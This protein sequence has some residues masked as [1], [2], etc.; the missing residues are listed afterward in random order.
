MYTVPIKQVQKKI[1]Y[2][3][4]ISAASRCLAERRDPSVAVQKTYSSLKGTETQDNT[5]EIELLAC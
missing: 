3:T 1:P 2:P 4:A 5:P